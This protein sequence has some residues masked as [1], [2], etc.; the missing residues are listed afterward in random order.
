MKGPGTLLTQINIRWTWEGRGDHFSTTNMYVLNLRVNYPSQSPPTSS[1]PF[2]MK[3][4]FMACT[5]HDHDPCELGV[6]LK[7]L[8]GG[9]GG[10][11]CAID[12]KTYKKTNPCC[13]YT[14]QS[15][16]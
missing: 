14:Q 2:P 3:H 12:P 4:M 16:W 9:G 6:W 7:W 11:G 15:V 13:K 10:G 5:S 1:L 8:G